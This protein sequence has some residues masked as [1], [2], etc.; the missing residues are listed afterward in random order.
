MSNKQKTTLKDRIIS[1][2][3]LFS[4][5]PIILFGAIVLVNSIQTTSTFKKVNKAQDVLLTTDDM[6]LRISLMARQIRGYL[7]VGNAENA[8]E[9]FQKQKNNFDE[10]AKRAENLI[11]DEG[12]DKQEIF[13]EMIKL[14][15]EFDTLA[16]TTFRLRDEG[17]QQQAVDNYLR[18]S[19][20]IVGQFDK[21]NQEIRNDKLAQLSTNINQTNISLIVIEILAVAIP[22]ISFLISLKLTTDLTV[23]ITDRIERVEKVAQKIAKGDL[24]DPVTATEELDEIGNLQ[25]AF[26]EMAKTLTSLVHEIQKTGVQITST[27]TQ[28]AASGKQLEATLTEQGASTNYVASTAKK[29]AATSSEL[30]QTMNKVEQNSQATAEGAGDSQQELNQMEKTMLMLVD[31]T[32]SISNKLGAISAKAHS[33][34][35]IITTITKVADQTNLLSL[36]A[37]IEA[38]K[39]GEF[40]RGFAV[41]AREIRRLADQTA[42]AA[43]DIETMVKEMQGAVSTGVTEMGKFSQQVEQGVRDVQNISGKLESII[44]RVQTITPRFQEVGSSVIAQSEGAVQISGAMEELSQ[45]SAQTA[46]SLREINRTLE[47]LNGVARGLYQKIS[48][49]KIR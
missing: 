45:A 7:L 39:A 44:D 21:L 38:E 3:L 48:H 35:T 15:N 8:I 9:S 1:R 26:H 20:R 6:V 36:N 34:N 37:A 41:V 32:S 11:K 4:S 24:T 2:I 17:Q 18:E 5:L 19:K 30:V 31:A 29:I 23:E 49:F 42:L 14:A 28:I 16:K 22:I 46:G 47:E 33:I 10:S 27:V 25:N 13:D 40:G 43:L 12:R